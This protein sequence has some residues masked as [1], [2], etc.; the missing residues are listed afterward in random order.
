MGK[1]TDYDN[2][3]LDPGNVSY[4]V[5]YK[6]PPEATR[7][8]PGRSGNPSGRPK[9]VKTEKQALEEVLNKVYTANGPNGPVHL[10]GN[11]VVVQALFKGATD[12]KI[13]ALKVLLARKDALGIDKDEN[14]DDIAPFEQHILN[15]FL[16][17][18]R[19]GV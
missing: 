13:G 8:Q 17:H 12:G 6:K 1:H 15:A 10:T 18:A 5:G 7:F 11:D 16:D 4:P 9:K 2:Q 14:A 19:R 3:P